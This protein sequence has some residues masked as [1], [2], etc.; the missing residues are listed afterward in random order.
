MSPGKPLTNFMTPLLAYFGH[1]K[2]GS[3]WIGH[4]IRGVCE[5]TGLRLVH[6]DRES[7][8][9]GDINTLRAR[10][11][12]DFWIF[13]NAD[14]NFV[15]DVAVR[16]VHVVRDPRDLI[17]SAYFSHRYSHPEEGWPRLRHYRRYLQKLSKRD[18]LLA[19]IEFSAGTLAHLLIWDYQQPNILEVRFEDLVRADQSTF[20]RIFDFLRLLPAPL[21]RENL[22]QI[23]EQYSFRNLS[24]GRA[25]GQEDLQSHYRKGQPGDWRNH[26]EPVHIEYFRKLYNPVLLKLGYEIR[27]DWYEHELAAVPLMA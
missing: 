22:R 10:D 18:G 16:G 14:I 19:E 9:Q 20:Q 27:E 17:V 11:P 13:S 25:P 4:V 1:H 23:V 12:F 15:R 2:C 21:D 26:F 5:R 3:I 7:Q 24:G 8:F 6:H